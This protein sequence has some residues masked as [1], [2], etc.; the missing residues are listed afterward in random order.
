MRIVEPSE[1]VLIQ[2]WTK[3][4]NTPRPG[5]TR[6]GIPTTGIANLGILVSNGTMRPGTKDVERRT[7][8]RQ[9]VGS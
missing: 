8:L 7:Y 6:E 9:H 4:D 5:H 3:F 1:H 2:V